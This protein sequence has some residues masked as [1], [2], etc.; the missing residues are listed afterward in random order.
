MRLYLFSMLV[1]V[2]EAK[3]PNLKHPGKMK[4]V[5]NGADDEK[6]NSI[7]IELK[8][9]DMERMNIRTAGDA[10]EYLYTNH[11]ETNRSFFNTEGKLAN[12]TICIINETDWEIT[13]EDTSPVRHGDEIILISSLHGG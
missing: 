9:D 10:L 1:Q 2:L 4:F 7:S 8:R 6:L 11:R 5:F 12:G 13:G 3:A